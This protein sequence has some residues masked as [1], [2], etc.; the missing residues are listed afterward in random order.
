MTA[1]ATAGRRGGRGG[2]V[3]VEVRPV[4]A[5]DARA[6]GRRRRRAR[7]GRVAGMG[8]VWTR[9]TTAIRRRW[10]RLPKLG[11][12]T[13]L[14]ELEALTIDGDVQQLTAYT[15][16][17]SSS[18]T[19]PASAASRRSTRGSKRSTGSTPSRGF[20]ILGFPCNQFGKQEPGTEAE[21]ETFCRRTYGVRFPMFAKI[22]VNGE[23]RPP[24]YQWL[25]KESGGLLGGEHQVELHQVP[26]RQ[27]RQGHRALRVDHTPAEAE[28]RHRE[29]PRRTYPLR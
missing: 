21:I 28:G 26:R 9:R 29:G 27:R 4:G 12:V 24:L 2:G 19:S 10:W 6:R 18:S 13:N 22:D 15:A 16:R 14:F 23:G 5:V 3:E 20:V 8:T 25:K 7:P 11:G 17:S 1:S